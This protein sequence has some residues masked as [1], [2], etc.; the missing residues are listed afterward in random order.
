M[1]PTRPIPA[2]SLAAGFY[3]HARFHKVDAIIRIPLCDVEVLDVIC[4]KVIVVLLEAAGRQ[5]EDSPFLFPAI[6]PKPL[7]N[8][9]RRAVRPRL[10]GFAPSAGGY[11]TE[12]LSADFERLREGPKCARLMVVFGYSMP[13]AFFE[14]DMVATKIK[15]SIPC[16]MGF[17]DLL[18]ASVFRMSSHF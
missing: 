11:R 18:Y 16:Q 2:R 12:R 8:R 15:C 17:S 1:K 5:E 14:G 6:G 9:R 4:Y 3:C 10:P 7:G 13:A